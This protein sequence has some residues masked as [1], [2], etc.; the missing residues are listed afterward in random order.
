MLVWVAAILR[1][2][3]KPAGTTLNRAVRADCE[4]GN[5]RR[6]D[7]RGR[8]GNSTRRPQQRE[9]GEVLSALISYPGASTLSWEGR[10]VDRVGGAA[11]GDLG[12]LML[13]VMALATAVACFA[14]SRRQ[15]CVGGVTVL[16]GVLLLLPVVLVTFLYWAGD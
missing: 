7:T 12:L 5:R 8:W 9:G 14:T 4:A 2:Q 13:T 6:G 10:P 11:M 3:D 16:I 15:R 1:L